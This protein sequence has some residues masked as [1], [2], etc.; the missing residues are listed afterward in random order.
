MAS[1]AAGSSCCCCETRRG[2][3]V[4]A[5]VVG[6]TASPCCWVLMEGPTGDSSRGVP[7]AVVGAG[8]EARGTP[9][10]GGIFP[11]IRA[12]EAGWPLLLPAPT[13]AC[14][15]GTLMASPAASAKLQEASGAA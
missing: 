11:H 5:A 1:A 10:H 9:T 15:P 8:G 6:D 13:M 14:N 3:N 7:P 4:N 12:A 2:L